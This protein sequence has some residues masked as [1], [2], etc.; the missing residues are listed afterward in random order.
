MSHIKLMTDRE[1]TEYRIKED[2]EYCNKLQEQA[3]YDL[4]TVCNNLTFV[5]KL[6]LQIK[7]WKEELKEPFKDEDCNF[8][9]G[10][11]R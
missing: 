8:A 6:R 4:K 5:R 11:D 9:R 10:D 2:T 7:K 3:E 1:L